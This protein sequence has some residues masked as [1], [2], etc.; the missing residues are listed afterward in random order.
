MNRT[1]ALDERKNIRKSYSRVNGKLI[2][3]EEKMFRVYGLLK[4]HVKG[5]EGIDIDLGGRVV[6]NQNKGSSGT[7]KQSEK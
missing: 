2:G 5:K 6:G 7:G 3:K 1:K 4:V